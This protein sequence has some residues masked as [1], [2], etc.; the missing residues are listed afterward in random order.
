MYDDWPLI[1]FPDLNTSVL[2][3]FTKE[4]GSSVASSI[5]AEL[6]Y[7]GA[8]NDQQQ[9]RLITE[10]QLRWCIQILNHALTL[11]LHTDREFTTVEQTVSVYTHWL[12][13]LTDTPDGTIP[14][15]LLQTPEK[16]FRTIVDALRSVFVRRRVTDG[17][18]E[19]IVN[20][21]A[22][23][24]ETILENIKAIT[25]FASRK[26][27]DEVWSRSLSFMLNSA[28]IL[29]AEP[30]IPDDISCRMSCRMVDTLLE[31]WLRAVSLEQIPS[32]S[33]WRTLHVLFLKW[34]HHVPVIE[35]WARKLLSLTVLVCQSMYGSKSCTINIGD[36]SVTSLIS[37][38]TDD[39]EDGPSLLFKSWM[40]IL[41]LLGPPSAILQHEPA[42]NNN[43]TNI[44]S[45]DLPTNPSHL[46][47]S[48]FIATTAIQ[49]MIDLFYG[50]NKV[51]IEFKETE[52]LQ[53]KWDQANNERMMNQN[54][55]Q[56]GNQSRAPTGT[57]M[58]GQFGGGFDGEKEKDTTTTLTN[59]NRASFSS[60]ISGKT[61]SVTANEKEKIKE[62]KEKKKGKNDSKPRGGAPSVSTTINGS[63]SIQSTQQSSQAMMG[64]AQKAPDPPMKSSQ[65]TQRPTASQFVAHALKTNPGYQPFVGERGPKSEK[66]L[67]LTMNWLM[68]AAMAHPEW[69]TKGSTGGD[70]ADDVISSLSL[71]S[72]D[73]DDSPAAMQTQQQ[74]STTI[75]PLHHSTGGNDQPTNH[76]FQQRSDSYA[77]S[78]ASSS[79]HGGYSSNPMSVSD[80]FGGIESTNGISAG[81]A[82][83]VGTLARIIC[84]KR[85]TETIPPQQLSQFFAM[86]YETLVE[87]DRLILCSLF[88]YG[89][90]IFRLNL[91]GIEA[92]LPHWLFALDVVLIESSK[93]RLHPSF[94]EAEMRHHCLRSLA[95]VISWPTVFGMTKIPQI[96]GN[97][98]QLKSSASTYLH[99]RPRLYK[100]LI[101]S[102]RNETDPGNLQLTL[103]MCSVLVVESATFDLGLNEE[104]MREMMRIATSIN[105]GQPEKGLC[106]SFVRGLI[107]AICDRL[108]RQ[109][110][111]GDFSVCLAAIDV[112]HTISSL[113]SAVLF[114]NRDMSAGSLI[115]SS[116]CRFIETQLMKP[117]PMHSK[118]LHSSVVSAYSC[119][120][121]WLTAAPMLAECESVLHTVAEAVQLGVTGA[122]THEIPVNEK[123]AASKRVLEAAEYLLFSLFCV[124]GRVQ[125]PIGDERRL[126]YHCGPSM[127]DTPRFMHFLINGD[128]LLSIHEATHIPSFCSGS[129]CIVYV[130]RSPMHAASIG[131]AQLRP[132]TELGTTENEKA[133]KEVLNGQK[134]CPSSSQQS[135]TPL[136]PSSLP[137][138]PSPSSSSSSP[139]SFVSPRPPPP[140]PPT[141]G[142]QFV[143]PPEFYKIS[144]KLDS[145][146]C[147]LQST[148]EVESIINRL[149]DTRITRHDERNIW[150]ALKEEQRRAEPP[151]TVQVCNSIRVFLY[152]M[153]LIDKD[154][155]GS[156]FIYLDSGQNVDFYRDLHEMVDSCP[157]RSLQTAFIFYVKVGQRSA[158]DILENALNI[159]NTSGDFCHL[160]SELGEGVEV[161]KH[162]GW[163]GHTST[164][165]S[166]DR[167]PY[168]ER[169]PVDHYILDGVTHILWWSNSST[170]IAFVTPSE[171]S[172]S[173]FK[174]EMP[175][176]QSARRS[177]VK[178][179]SG[180]TSSDDVMH[181]R[182]D[183]HHQNGQG[184]RSKS[185]VSNMS[186][187]GGNLSINQPSLQPY[188]GG[189][190]SNLGTNALPR[191]NTDLRVLI[192]WLE[193]YED[194]LYFPIEDLLPSCDTGN[195]RFNATQLSP[196][197]QGGNSRIPYQVIFLYPIEPGLIQVAIRGTSTRFGD[198]GPLVDGLIVSSQCLP[199]LLRLTLLNLTNRN[200]AEVENYQLT[201]IKRRMAI[202]D[203]GKKYA[204]TINYEDFLIKL[205]QK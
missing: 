20:R 153:G 201:H 140:N 130:R 198:P 2:D 123:K 164:A 45:R 150:A 14:A 35:S 152:D 159:Q 102:L 42:I 101:F 143:I 172:V 88:Y 8:K 175:P 64:M 87:K 9:L 52:I 34:R 4:T 119:I 54:G 51:S 128:T 62:D 111:A 113:H 191:R 96:G 133:P 162:E 91:S 193:R 197:T 155:F 24:I 94:P 103:A 104:Q 58:S 93:L 203:F 196:N 121:S 151:K 84:S 90:T 86:I 25:M 108:S 187:D 28:D 7:E 17:R 80:S 3:L 148:P 59:E 11:P 27:Q 135:S 161:E 21:Q 48:F 37:T 170:E 195:D 98:T 77:G 178:S 192:G 186:N 124:V 66:L 30:P 57:T 169:E 26:Y 36:E 95:T 55:E 120:V 174:Q 33:Y 144:C 81:R 53:R 67:M 182:G 16:Y 78:T 115:V 131:I 82:T 189:N 19:L 199:S 142:E 171:R 168:E 202:S 126:L 176:P 179:Y 107:S 112:L 190:G 18:L 49:R 70:I 60:S 75:N 177:S 157:N 56:R 117:P 185:N 194:L 139:S 110:W 188:S 69:E 205:I 41:S 183:V 149:S 23:Q 160:L 146:I 125:R 83:A 85:T 166:S 129:S 44:D 154:V 136:S 40:D 200:V 184:I 38:S 61:G 50:D 127:I 122:R 165:Y 158:V 43:K 15:P 71:C 74:S 116:L 156:E 138:P 105:Q 72:I 73:F 76:Y 141:L 65:P 173:L 1:E 114:S 79:G 47:L 204:S 137:T 97:V 63:R 109:E 39:D 92:L 5:L 132:F 163:T 46:P 31:L 99:L 147:E 68:E 22:A 12:R 29:L 32:S 180:R 89:H 106:S 13:A 134:S 167:K 145:S 118:D 10:E 100:T 181:A 6:S